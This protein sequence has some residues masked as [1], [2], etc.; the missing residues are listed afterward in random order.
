MQEY[1]TI[2]IPMRIKRKLEVFA[3]KIR[4]KSLTRAL[5]KAIDIAHK[6]IDSFRGNLDPVLDSLKKARDV[7]KTD[8]SLIDE[9]LYGG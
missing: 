4:E 8:A 5:E 1:T 2:R 9:Y 6:N 7:G 3:K